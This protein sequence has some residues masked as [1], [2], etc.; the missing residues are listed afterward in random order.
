MQ[1]C[2]VNFAF[3]DKKIASKEKKIES[4]NKKIAS[5]KKKIASK[6]KKTVSKKDKDIEFEDKDILFEN[7]SVEFIG[8]S[9]FKK[10]EIIKTPFGDGI[11]IRNDG[12]KVKQNCMPNELF[13]EST[14][15]LFNKKKD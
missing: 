13:V 6:K 5:K 1:A 4:K 10:I 7:E 14:F 2:R 3:N 8:P 15:F 9:P 11:C 12:N